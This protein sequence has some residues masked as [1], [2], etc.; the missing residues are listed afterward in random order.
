[1]MISLKFVLRVIGKWGRK[2]QSSYFSGMGV[3]WG[4]A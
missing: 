4:C 1:M 3:D 2:K